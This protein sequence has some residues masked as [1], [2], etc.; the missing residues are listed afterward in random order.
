MITNIPDIFFLVK[1]KSE[2]GS[3]LNV[4]DNCL[5]N[6]GIGNTN[7]LKMSSII[8]PGCKKVKP[9]YIPEG[10][11][12]PVA[13]SFI[14]S[15]SPGSLISAAIAVAIPKDPTLPGLIMEHSGYESLEKIGDLAYNMAVE[16]FETR[17]FQIKEIIVEGIEH[18]V[19]KKGG[20]FAAAALWYS[21]E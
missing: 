20:T 14:Y 10:S 17:G 13:Y 1:G 9:I 18:R 11:L 6:A 8:P 21:N 7:L 19:E 3:E 15:E 2:G 5:L 12:L 16:G 4:F